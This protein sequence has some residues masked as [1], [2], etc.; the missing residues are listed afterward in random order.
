MDLPWFRAV[1]RYNPYF[2]LF[3]IMVEAITVAVKARSLETGG[4]AMRL[5]TLDVPSPSLY[6]LGWVSRSASRSI[7]AVA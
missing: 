7:E 2:L 6:I 5:D 1:N 3:S 4:V